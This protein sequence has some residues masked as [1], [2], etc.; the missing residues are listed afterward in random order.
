[1]MMKRKR[2]EML[3]LFLFPFVV[4]QPYKNNCVITLSVVCCCVWILF[5]EN[6]QVVSTFV[7]TPSRNIPSY[8]VGSIQLTD[9]C[10]GNSWA[11]SFHS[12]LK[13]QRGSSPSFNPIRKCSFIRD[14]SKIN[15]GM[16]S[17]SRSLLFI[18]FSSSSSSKNW[19]STT[20]P[21]LKPSSY[22]LQYINTNN[23]PQRNVHNNIN[24]NDNGKGSKTSSSSSKR[25][26][27]R[28]NAQS[29]EKILFNDMKN[30]TTNLMEYTTSCDILINGLVQLS[31]ANHPTQIL[32]AGRQLETLLLNRFLLDQVSVQ[33]QERVV[34][35]TSIVGL[36]QP[37]AM[38]IMNHMILERSYIPSEMC[39]EA[40]FLCLRQ[41]GRINQME[42]TLM[43]LGNL[44]TSSTNKQ[45][46]IVVGNQQSTTNDNHLSMNGISLYSFNIYLACLCDLVTKSGVESG[47]SNSDG[48]D[49]A[50]KWI[51]S[52]D[53][54]DN[55]VNHSFNQTT[56]SRSMSNRISLA[57]K[58]L[59]ILPDAVSYATVIQAASL[60]KNETLVNWIWQELST[61]QI[62]PNI[63]AYNAKMRLL[64]T[65][66]NS[67]HL[68]QNDQEILKIIAENSIL[69][70]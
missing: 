60:M 30:V 27:L 51:Q 58:T 34:K 13:Q 44:A 63:V 55:E 12:T 61:R 21:E 42:Q 54:D 33:V 52:I 23:E 17:S 1:M 36:V 57:Q 59:G 5:P 49:R 11:S 68:Q 16:L 62:N 48:I 28:W 56:T 39:Q 2:K 65:K 41:L 4:L 31:V 37:L 46:V 40:L 70:M 47:N 19:T 50:W 26:Q 69:I 24:N 64:T 9:P 32:I 15:K 66:K 10:I 25:N 43:H 20:T 29:V 35:V 7:T 22:Q 3:S 45:N 6:S 53:I 67:I 18:L 8:V 14:I 38:N